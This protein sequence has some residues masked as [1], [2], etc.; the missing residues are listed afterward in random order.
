MHR[1]HVGQVHLGAY[2][3]V[4]VVRE[5]GQGDVRDHL[6][7]LLVGVTGLP[8]GLEGFVRDVAALF[9]DLSDKSQ[10][11]STLGIVGL[12]VLRLLTLLLARTLL[13]RHGGVGRQSVVAAV[14]VRDRHGDKLL[15][16]AVER[17]SLKVAG[18][19]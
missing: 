3:V 1:L 19:I 15:H 14:E 8:N 18:E 5:R 10:R 4:D 11:R 9:H 7:D 2:S 13:L 16:L 6:H 12:E 17:S